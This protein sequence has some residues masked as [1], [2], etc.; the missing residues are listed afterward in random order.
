L[1]ADF[2]V[3]RGVSL[4]LMFP[5]FEVGLGELGVF[6]APVAVPKTPVYKHNGPI[7]GEDDIG[8]AGQVLPV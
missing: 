1:N 5:K 2:D 6:A 4:N 7:F 8:L 3:V